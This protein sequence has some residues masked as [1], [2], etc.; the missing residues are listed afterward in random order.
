[1]LL[2][3]CL[4]EKIKRDTKKVFQN[5]TELVIEVFQTV[6]GLNKKTLNEMT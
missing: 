4:K 3:L 1:M 5:F 2:A 6:Y